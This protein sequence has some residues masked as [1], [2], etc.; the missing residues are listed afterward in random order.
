METEIEYQFKDERSEKYLTGY[1]MGDIKW[2]EKFKN[3]KLGKECT[4]WMSMSEI[5]A[6]M[7]I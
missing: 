4:L 5:N 1:F 7:F 6:E 2:Q 3:Q